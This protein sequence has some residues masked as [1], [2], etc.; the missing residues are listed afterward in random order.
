MV[1]GFLTYRPQ[2][3]NRRLNGQRFD[4]VQQFGGMELFGFDRSCT[5]PL[6]AGYGKTMFGAKKTV[7]AVQTTGV[8]VSAATNSGQSLR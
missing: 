6:L 3:V 8:Q 7:Q 4:E 1:D 2:T 5:L